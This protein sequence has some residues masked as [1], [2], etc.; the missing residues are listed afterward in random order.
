MSRTRRI[1]RS[2]IKRLCGVVRGL[3]AWLL[4]LGVVKPVEARRVLEGK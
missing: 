1:V 2:I 4:G 3:G